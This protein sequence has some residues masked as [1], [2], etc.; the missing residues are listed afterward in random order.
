MFKKIILSTILGVSLLGS[1]SGSYYM[2]KS[3]DVTTTATTESTTEENR[4]D[5][6]NVHKETDSE[7]TTSENTTEEKTEATTETPSEEPAAE[8]DT[9]KGKIKITFGPEKSGW[10]NDSV[11]VVVTVEE[12]KV[13][14]NFKID[15]VEA[16]AGANGSWQDITDE[17]K[18]EITE[19][20]NV[21]IKVTDQDGNEYEKS[22]FIKCFDTVAPTLNA[23]VSEGL[24][25]IM[26]YDTESGV[27]H[28]YI[29]EYRYEPDENGVIAVRLQK[30]DA[31]YQFFYIYAIDNAG[32]VS[33]TYTIQN[34]YWTDPSAQTEDDDEEKED[35]AESLPDN[36][37]AKTTGTSTA[38]VTSVTNEKG[39]DI[40]E[41]IDAKQFY[42]IVTSD[43]Q[44]Y[45][46]VIDMTAAKSGS[47]EENAS[48]VGEGS[49][50]YTNQNGTVYLLTS[51]S[52]QNLLNFS[53]DGEQTLPQ[54]SVAKGNN[55]NDTR[56][57][58]NKDETVTTEEV[59][60][61]TTETDAKEEEVKEDKKKGGSDFILYIVVGLV[62]LVVVAVKILGGKKGKLTASDDEMYGGSAN[63]D[64]DEVPLDEL[65][66]SEVEVDDS[67]NR[68]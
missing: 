67:E 4:E 7:G 49:Q 19:N 40:V 29:N 28:V 21:Y 46:L 47:S 68:E 56:V 5:A 53:N 41:N 2:A 58:P 66:E 62:A 43:G 55:I 36:A 52:N 61:E 63:P 44:Q 59:V 15:T 57:T 6:S 9:T 38:E 50:A 24:L 39:E 3:A 60:E 16:K 12:V 11:N 37:D 8:V 48:V 33:T 35:P 45:F 14:K 20:C 27:K 25:N 65:N 17:M 18:F 26:T 31:S 22:R 13:P 23:A 1:T 30:F 64:E 51:V 10:F 34:P 54:N 32:N 42:S